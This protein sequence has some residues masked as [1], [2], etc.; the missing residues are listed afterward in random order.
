MKK[1][2]LSLLTMDFSVMIHKLCLTLKNNKEYVI[3]DQIFRSATSIGANLR[4]AQYASSKA[5]FVNKLRISLKEAIET[6][7]WLELLYKTNYI[8]EV[9]F[10]E[11]NSKYQAIKVLLIKS[12]N[13]AESNK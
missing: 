2:K 9:E 4:E 7:Y 6:E 10:S 13:T 1:D 12:V 8:N 11:Y 3:S 5:D